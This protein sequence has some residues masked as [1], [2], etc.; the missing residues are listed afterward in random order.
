MIYIQKFEEYPYNKAAAVTVGKFDGVHLGH[1]LLTEQLVKQKE[2]GMPVVVVTF[3]SQPAQLVEN[4]DIRCIITG[5]E[6]RQMLA[7]AGVDVMLELPFTKAFMQLSPEAFISLL[8]KKLH[9]KYMV[10]GSDFRFGYR[11]AGEIGMLRDLSTMF[12]FDLDVI[13]KRKCNKRDISSTFIRDEIADGRIKNANRLL[14]YPYF[15]YGRIVHGN[16]IGSSILS[17][18]TINILPPAAKLL[19]PYGVYLTNVSF[20]EKTYH[21]ITNVGIR[22]TVEEAQKKISVETYLLDYDGDAYEKE[23]RVD[24]LDMMRKE[25]KFA[26]LEELKEQITADVEAAN[27]FFGLI[28]K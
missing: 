19:P 8:V 9:M 10:V 24:F 23:A 12:H 11:G 4:K 15:V 21:G 6:R 7:S 16:K 27:D 14:G 26:S 28:K 2:Q 3:D 25:I 17:F 22:P 5:D 13:E 20:D 18:P 1:R